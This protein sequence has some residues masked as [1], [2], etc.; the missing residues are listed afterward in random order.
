MK[1]SSARFSRRSVSSLSIKSRSS[2][3]KAN[4]DNSGIEGDE[5]G[6]GATMV[7]EFDEAFT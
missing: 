1:E 7:A 4:D 2:V 5:Y 6:T 3:K